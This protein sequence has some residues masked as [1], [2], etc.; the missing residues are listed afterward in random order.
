MHRCL[1]FCVRKPQIPKYLPLIVCEGFSSHKCAEGQS[2][3]SECTTCQGRKEAIRK[4]RI[5]CNL[6]KQSICNKTLTSRRGRREPAWWRC[7]P[8]RC[9]LCGHTW[10][11]EMWKLSSV[12]SSMIL[13]RW[14]WWQEQPTYPGWAPPGVLGHKRCTQEQRR[15]FLDTKIRQGSPG[16]ISY[17]STLTV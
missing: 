4:M 15:W 7:T 16:I 12:I 3:G 14:Y 17:I 6:I 10:I 8:P 1:C 5:I 13:W 11:K 2:P 9:H